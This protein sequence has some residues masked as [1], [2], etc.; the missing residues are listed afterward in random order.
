[1][2]EISNGSARLGRALLKAT[3]YEMINSA[4]F[5]KAW[6]TKSI[7]LQRCIINH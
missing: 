3:A 1:M 4:G 7:H 6:L 5:S 2:P